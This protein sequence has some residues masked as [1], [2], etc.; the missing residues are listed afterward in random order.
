MKTDK[1]VP[2]VDTICFSKSLADDVVEKQL[3]PPMALVQT[4]PNLDGICEDLVSPILGTILEPLKSLR[5]SLDTFIDHGL[6]LFCRDLGEPSCYPLAGDSINCVSPSLKHTL[7]GLGFVSP[8]H[9]GF[10]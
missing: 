7:G 5:F 10:T 4:D 9:G 6:D 8:F 1:V 3:S 2:G